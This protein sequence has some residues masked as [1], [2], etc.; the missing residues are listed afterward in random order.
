MSCA[1]TPLEIH[2]EA[3]NMI[4]LLTLHANSPTTSAV[5]DAEMAKLR[6]DGGC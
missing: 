2:I 1:E 4:V 3:K 5:Y 6:D